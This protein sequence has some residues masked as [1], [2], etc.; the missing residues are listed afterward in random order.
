M[1]TDR[2]LYVLCSPDFNNKHLLFLWSGKTSM[3]HF[4]SNCFL[5][6]ESAEGNQCRWAIRRLLLLK[7][8][9]LLSTCAFWVPMLIHLCALH[10]CWTCYNMWGAEDMP[11]WPAVLGGLKPRTR[12][13]LHML[14][15]DTIFLTASISEE[16]LWSSE[17][18]NLYA[19]RA[20]YPT[21]KS[22][23]S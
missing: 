16:Q 23:V 12:D 21:A 18:L 5:S 13:V 2:K 20:D 15:T 22:S 11:T 19:W 3:T 6:T 10:P 7:A 17:I 9:L 14:N 8:K 1:V 4:W